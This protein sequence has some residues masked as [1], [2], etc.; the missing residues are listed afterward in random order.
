M[1]WTGIV[2]LC[3]D[4]FQSCGMG[5]QFPGQ[6]KLQ[7]AKELWAGGSSWTTTRPG[8]AGGQQAGGD[9]V[10][11]L[12]MTLDSVIAQWSPA[13]SWSGPH[14]ALQA[15]GSL[16][17]VLQLYS[18]RWPVAVT[19]LS[20]SKP[21]PLRSWSLPRFLWPPPPP[22]LPPMQ[23]PLTW[24]LSPQPLLLGFPEESPGSRCYSGMP[25][26]MKKRK[27]P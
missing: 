20:S 21:P 11:E 6:W 17:L 14:T 18:Q 24:Y 4:W 27:D 7:V 26:S 1:K 5:P 22:L 3:R 13:G 23:V 19:A 16:W 9:R 12:V 2:L 10:S 25:S 15:S 8:T